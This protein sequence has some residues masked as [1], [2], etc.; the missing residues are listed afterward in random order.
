VRVEGVRRVIVSLSKSS[1]VIV[2]LLLVFALAD[3]P[4]GYYTFLRWAVFLVAG[5]HLFSAEVRPSQTGVILGFVVLG[6]LFNPIAPVYLTR[7]I[8]S[9]VNIV[10]AVFILLSFRNAGAEAERGRES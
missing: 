6:I 7:E 9:V 3:W 1:R 5:L 8:W 4:Y 2:A 10:G